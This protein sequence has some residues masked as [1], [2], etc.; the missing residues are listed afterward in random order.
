M[1]HGVSDARIVG[2]RVDPAFVDLVDETTA[3]SGS[4][5]NKTKPERFW[6]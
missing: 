1:A 6:L 3:N 5:P 2:G 4:E